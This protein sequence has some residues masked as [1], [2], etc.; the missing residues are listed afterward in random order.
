MNARLYD[1]YRDTPLWRA[2]SDIVSELQAT[3]ELKIET[4]PEYVI[5]Y[6]C[7]ELAQ[8]WIVASESLRRIS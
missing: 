3:G 5:G 4:A 1:Q 2:V 6:M 7:Q 8:K